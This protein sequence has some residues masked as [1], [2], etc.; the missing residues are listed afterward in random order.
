MKPPLGTRVISPQLL[1]FHTE[2]PS[3]VSAQRNQTQWADGM[4]S[5][6][7]IAKKGPRNSVEGISGQTGDGC[8]LTSHCPSSPFSPAHLCLL[9]E[10]LP[11]S[12]TSLGCVE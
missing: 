8:S 3:R 9:G 4:D 2:K 11:A 10:V 6:S 1:S 12:A 5:A 7:P